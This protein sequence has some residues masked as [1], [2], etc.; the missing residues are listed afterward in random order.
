MIEM[1]LLLL[2]LLSGGRGPK[3]HVTITEVRLQSPV[4][5]LGNITTLVKIR[6]RWWFCYVNKHV[7]FEGAVECF[8]MRQDRSLSPTLTKCCEC[9]NTT[10][11]NC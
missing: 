9:L 3:K 8:S 7:V 6:E 1:H 10:I 2:H 11:K 5:C 4:C